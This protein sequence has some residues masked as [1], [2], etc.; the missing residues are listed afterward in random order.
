MAAGGG[1][2][3]N[4]YCIALLQGDSTVVVAYVGEVGG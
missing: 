4:I 1:Q 2:E 3:G